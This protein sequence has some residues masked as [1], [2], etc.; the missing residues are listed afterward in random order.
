MS[1]H[2]TTY[3]IL[4]LE[5]LQEKYSANKGLYFAFI[6]SEKALAIF[7]LA[8]NDVVSWALRKLGVKRGGLGLH[9]QYIGIHEVELRQTALSVMIRVL[10][11]A[12]CYL[13]W[14]W[15]LFV[16]IIWYLQARHLRVQKGN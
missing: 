15:E 16:L 5:Q 3:A 2:G 6:E 13:S 9:R 12:H 1:G 4:S 11:S 8:L 10:C 14:C 7:A